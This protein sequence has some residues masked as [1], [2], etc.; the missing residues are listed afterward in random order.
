VLTRMNT[1]YRCAMRHGRP[2]WETVLEEA[3][4]QG[5]ILTFQNMRIVV[6]EVLAP[7]KSW[8]IL[9]LATILPKSRRGCR[10]NRALSHAATRL[11]CASTTSSHN[12]VL[13]LSNQS[14][15]AS[16]DQKVHNCDHIRQPHPEHFASGLGAN[17]FLRY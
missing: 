5:T 12:K 13:K 7:C 15:H 9:L 8:M 16:S 11:F 3:E 2:S 6:A 14:V 10:R 4:E 1:W 17:L